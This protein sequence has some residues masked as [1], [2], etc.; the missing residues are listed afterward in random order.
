MLQDIENI[1]KIRD[2]VP[3]PADTVKT[4][5]RVDAP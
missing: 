5:A 4:T 3:M 1:F 2:L